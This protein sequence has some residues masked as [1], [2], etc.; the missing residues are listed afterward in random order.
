MKIRKM[1]NSLRIFLI[2]FSLTNF[3]ST[4][5]QRQNDPDNKKVIV[6]GID[7]LTVDGILQAKTPN[8]D[9]IKTNGRFTLNAQAHMPSKSS[10]NWM[11]MMSSVLPEKHRVTKNGFD[12]NVY[13]D[14]PSCASSPDYFP[15]IFTLLKQQKPNSHSALIYQW[16]G[17]KKL[18][19]PDDID[20][21]KN[22]TLK[23]EGSAK[24]GLKQFN[25]NHPDL[26]FLHFNLVDLKGHLKGYKS[27]AYYKA[28]ERV[29]GLIKDFI[30]LTKKDPNLVLFLVSDHGGIDKNHGGDTPQELTVPFMIYGKS[31]EAGEILEKVNNKDLAPTLLEVLNLKMHE[32]WEGES[33][34]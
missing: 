32:C 28:V 20:Y 3:I 9:F 22:K 23:A 14:N 12:K 25:K 16:P 4:S 19:N 29:D 18:I 13:R 21:L 6:I 8:I 1:W 17:F 34:L 10:P 5:A 31:I 7:G 27:P 30:D 33:V 11:S 2:I 15:T 24:K 26:L